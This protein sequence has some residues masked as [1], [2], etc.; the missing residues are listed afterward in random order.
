[1]KEEIQRLLKATPFVP[2]VVDV[3]EDLAY[4]IATHDHA[5]AAGNALVI[6]DDSGFIDL[7]PWRHIR[8]VHYLA[9]A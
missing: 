9:E 3:A 4:S 5:N 1:M 7:I 2:F 6:V 8:R